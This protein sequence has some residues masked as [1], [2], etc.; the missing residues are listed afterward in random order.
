MIK[1]VSISIFFALST[2]FNIFAQQRETPP[3]EFHVQGRMIENRQVIKIIPLDKSTW[4]LGMK[5]GYKVSISHFENGNYSEFQTIES[6]LKPASEVEFAE[7]G[8]VTEYAEAM[9]K[10]IYE[11]TF[12]PPGKSF[13]DMAAADKNMNR[14]FISYILLSSYDPELSAK[15]GLQ[16]DL[17]ATV[18][19]KIKIK[20]E[21]NNS[22]RQGVIDLNTDLFYTDLD[23][24]P[25]QIEPGDKKADIQWNHA[26][27]KKWIVAYQLERSDD[28][29]N[30][31]KLGIPRVFNKSAP[32]GKLGFLS[33]EDTLKENYSNY[34]YRLRGY[35]AFGM[36]TRPSEIVKITGRDLTP[37]QAPER[38]QVSQLARGSVSITWNQ[39]PAE[40]LA[41][42]QV[43]ASTSETGQYERLHEELLPESQHNFIFTFDHDPY[44]FYRVLAVDTAN[45]AAASDLGYLVVYDTIPPAIP[46]NIL[47]E[48]DSNNVVRLHW[49]RGKEKDLKG[50]RIYKAYH[51]TNGF[52]PITPIPLSDTLFV[53][54]I[55]MNRLDKKVYYSVSSIDMHYN[56]SKQSEPV[57]A[58]LIDQIPPTSPL[59]TNATFTP[60]SGVALTWNPSSS[61][62]VKLYSVHRFLENDS[63]VRR[64]ATLP[65]GQTTYTDNARTENAA[66]A[67]YYITATDSAG[68]VSEPSNGKRLLFAQK[69]V[70]EKIQI[71]SAEAKENNV[72][73]TWTL[74]QSIKQSILVYRSDDGSPF[75]LIDRVEN[76]ENYADAKVHKGKT[77]SYKIGTLQPS[78]YRSP[79]SEEV[80]VK[81]Q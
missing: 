54:S 63:S 34:W 64:I 52:I 36:L 38:V 19:N 62:D 28:G 60:Q 69:Q 8:N 47:A 23:C 5:N 12:V 48:A 41:G 25:L 77:Y 76:V 1:Q 27:F 29:V 10:I 32:A 56:N 7:A 15:S 42:F 18:S 3:A 43:I 13:D 44:L 81:F 26:D 57:A 75:Q 73:L 30:F 50:Y 17:P 49:N 6:I 80:Q 55:P 24:P 74:D 9:R 45:N 58:E 20:V 71:Q 46:V 59:L 2:A 65:P 37:P 40:D 72:I 79:L 53:D 4:F 33:V 66:F 61:A 16:L 21:I 31:E 11:E 70:E 78:G 35:D 22:D 67:E 68:N 14:L 51:P 39:Q